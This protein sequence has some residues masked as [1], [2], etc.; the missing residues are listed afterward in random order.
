MS[1]SICQTDPTTGACLAAPGPSVTTRI[2]AGATPTFGVFV[3]G[4]GV[5]Q[6]DPGA[7]RIHIRFKDAGGVT[8]GSTSVAVLTVPDV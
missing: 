2:D 5:V 4:G 8:R 6:F 7:S 1:L 3:A